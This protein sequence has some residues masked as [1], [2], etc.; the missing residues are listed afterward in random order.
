MFMIDEGAADGASYEEERLSLF[1]EDG[2][3]RLLLMLMAG[4]AFAGGSIGSGSSSSS[5]EGF[6]IIEG[7]SMFSVSHDGAP[8]THDC[9]AAIIACGDRSL[10]EKNRQSRESFSSLSSDTLAKMRDI[11][12]KKFLEDCL[13]KD[14]NNDHATKVIFDITTNRP[15]V[16]LENLKV[17]QGEMDK[18]ESFK[19]GLEN[20][21]SS[22]YFL[23]YLTLQ[24]VVIGKIHDGLCKGLEDCCKNEASA[25]HTMDNNSNAPSI[26]DT[27]KICRVIGDI[28][29]KCVVKRGTVAHN[30]LNSIIS[31]GRNEKTKEERNTAYVALLEYLLETSSKGEPAEKSSAPEFLNYIV[32]FAYTPD[33]YK[34]MNDKEEDITAAFRA[35]IDSDL[36]LSGLRYRQLAE[37]K[38]H[39]IEVTLYTCK[40]MQASMLNKFILNAVSKKDNK[41]K[42]NQ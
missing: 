27:L 41:T 11:S 29:Q 40:A 19:A 24:H 16:M 34:V 13:L 1:G 20:D 33:V 3:K 32:S 6:E 23:K 22:A 15:S 26:T 28:E 14:V 25:K 17:M 36:F 8:I 7:K 37:N 35:G 4:G 12:Y 10:S 38:L 9:I 18:T 31:A 5:M 2:M 42:D 30:S 39:S 21:L